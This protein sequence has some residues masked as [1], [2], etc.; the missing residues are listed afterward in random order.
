MD[1]HIV[2]PSG[3]KED[4]VFKVSLQHY[5]K[6]EG[7]VW[8][9]SYTRQSRYSKFESCADKSV[10]ARLCACANEQTADVEKKGDTAQNSVP[11]KMFGADTVV[12]DLDSGC[13]LF[14]K[15]SHGSTALTVEVTNVCANRTYK[16]KMDGG[17]KKIHF[18]KKLPIDVE[19]LPKT[20]YFLTS[21][22]NAPESTASFPFTANIQVKNDSSVH[23]ENLGQR[24]IL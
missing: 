23:F 11:R 21:M 24:D 5:A 6:P 18:S 9:T 4:E 13:L 12:K 15:R 19:L 14:L 10:D 7:N 20:F 8:V 16:F 1:L 22:K 3:Y 2:P 17:G